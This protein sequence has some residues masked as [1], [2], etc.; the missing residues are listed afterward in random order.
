[1]DAGLGLGVTESLHIIINI[2]DR[3]YGTVSIS[4]LFM[5]G[6]DLAV[7]GVLRVRR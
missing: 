7:A 6:L 1:M 2:E 4:L 5:A 3:G